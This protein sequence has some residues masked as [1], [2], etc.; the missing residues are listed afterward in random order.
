MKAHDDAMI[1]VRELTKSFG[2]SKAVDSLSFS[3]QAGH[4]T[5]FLGPNGAGKSTT[6]RSILGLITPTSGSATVT[7]VPYVQLEQPARVVGALLETQ[8]FHPQRT[9]GNHLKVLAAAAGFDQRRIAEVLAEVH[10]TDAA[11]KKVGAFSLGMRQR[12]GL[13]AALLGDPEILI[14]DEPANGLDPAG[15]RWLRGLLRS[16]ASRGRTVLV[17][18]HLLD[19]V[20]HIADEVV[21]ID[22]GR[23]VTHAPI[24]ELIADASGG[25]R[26]TT[27]QPER[28]RDAL[29]AAGVEAQQVSVTDLVART[30]GETLWKIA[31]DAAIPV[32]A[33]HDE[34]RSLEDIFFELTSRTEV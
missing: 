21:V 25:V 11:D 24:S 30:D 29:T 27:P 13:A 7:G 32:T 8:Q 12:L 14:L 3:V 6:L 26:A 4:V 17:S 20:A 28:L 15:I 2:A 19:E 18:S 33:M 10:L 23:F 31:V 22:R 1:E 34:Q 5:G 9:A 16:Y